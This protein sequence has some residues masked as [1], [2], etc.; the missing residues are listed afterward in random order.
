MSGDRT[1][2]IELDRPDKEVGGVRVASPANLVEEL[3]GNPPISVRNQRFEFLRRA[4]AKKYS[5][6]SSREDRVDIFYPSLRLA[7]DW[8]HAESDNNPIEGGEL[9]GPAETREIERRR[10]LLEA[11]G[12][13]YVSIRAGTE[14][15]AEAI[16]AAKARVANVDPV[17]D[18]K[19]EPDLGFR[20]LTARDIN[21]DPQTG[22]G[23]WRRE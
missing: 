11:H 2:G 18:R 10:D 15:N 7:V 3:L 8:W 17:E 12:I 19:P 21:G 1:L 5:S 9:R 22:I 16:A 20:V 14:V 6:A 23:V 4:E 13:V